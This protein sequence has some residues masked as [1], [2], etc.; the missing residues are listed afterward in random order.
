MFT[1]AIRLALA[2]QPGV[3]VWLLVLAI[4]GVLN[5]AIAAAYYLRVISAMY[6]TPPVTR[7]STRGGAG[8]MVGTLA[9]CVLVIVLSLWPG[10]ALRTAESADRLL[11]QSRTAVAAGLRGEPAT[12]SSYVGDQAGQPQKGGS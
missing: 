2:G 4:A 1:G 3:S 12:V 5:A 8:A 6:F 10:I 7:L 9:C 11:R